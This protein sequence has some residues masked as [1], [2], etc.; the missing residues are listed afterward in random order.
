MCKP[1]CLIRWSNSSCVL[2][3]A[4]WAPSDSQSS[5]AASYP[6]CKASDKIS[7]LLRKLPSL[8]YHPLGFCGSRC[9]PSFEC[10]RIRIPSPTVILASSA[11]TLAQLGRWMGTLPRRPCEATQSRWRP[12]QDAGLKRRKIST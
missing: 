3:V 7:L 8:P 12:R 9:R 4:R 10:C 11:E 6:A 2:K 5:L 1:K